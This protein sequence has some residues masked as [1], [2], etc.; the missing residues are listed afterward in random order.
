[1]KNAC[2]VGY[3]SIGPIHAESLKNAA[4]A[5][6]YAVCDID[7]D[8]AELCKKE[9]DAVVYTDFDEMLTDK[10]IDSVHICTPH[11]LHKDMAVKAMKADKHVVLEKPAAM[12]KDELDELIKVQHETGMCVCLMLQ[13]RTNPCI[14][15]M[16]SALNNNEYGKLIAMEGS[17][18]WHRDES[19]YNSAAWRGT[20]KYEGGGLLINQAIHMID[21]FDYLG[22]GI[23]S[24]C[25]SVSTKKLGNVIEVEDTADALFTMKDG[26]EACFYATNAHTTSKPFRLELEFEKVLLRYADS[27]LYKIDDNIEILATDT[28]PQTGKSYWGKG[29]SAVINQFYENYP[30]NN[31]YIKLS[32]GINTMKALFAM[33]ESN[34]KKILI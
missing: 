3:G 34:N 28:Q 16:K 25:A 15:A 4:R 9:Y 24:V 10:S 21:M 13:N 32:D 29:H 23:E 27:R 8:R 22:G 12:N 17:L 11:Y 31:D 2:V 30:R 19:Y 18:L 26:V 20:K 33:Y 6:L 7:K 5:T 14:K 1:M